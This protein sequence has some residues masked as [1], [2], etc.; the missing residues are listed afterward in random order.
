MSGHSLITNNIQM[1]FI[2]KSMPPIEHFSPTPAPVSQR[3]STVR[4][5][6]TDIVS[7]R[8]PNYHCKSDYELL[9]L[10]GGGPGYEDSEQISH[11]LDMMF[12]GTAL[13]YGSEEAL[14]RY[15]EMS[16]SCPLGEVTGVSTKYSERRLILT[17]NWLS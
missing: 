6:C 8:F 17:T 4:D 16:L 3:G 11:W 12:N 14:N 10:A 5:L 7:H 9:T 2:L 1:T 15:V 13:S